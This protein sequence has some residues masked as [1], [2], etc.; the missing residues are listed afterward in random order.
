M[1]NFPFSGHGKTKPILRLGST[2][3]T[4][5]QISVQA[6]LKTSLLTTGRSGQVFRLGSG[7]V[8]AN[9]PQ[10]RAGG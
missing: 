6:T 5:R 4:L 3:S 7:R 9:Y 10:H 8:K 2:L 1:R